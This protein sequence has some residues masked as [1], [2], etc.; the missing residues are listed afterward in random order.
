MKKFIN[1]TDDFLKE[2]LQGFGAAHKDI[3]TC[4][5]NPNFIIRSKVKEGKVSLIPG[6]GSGHEPMHGGFVGYGM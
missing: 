1:S 5:Y 6:G 2:S 4:H 3:V